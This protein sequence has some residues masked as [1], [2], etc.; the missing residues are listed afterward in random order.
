MKKLLFVILGG[1]ILFC[2][3]TNAQGKKLLVEINSLK[4]KEVIGFK[5]DNK[6]KLVYFDEKS[7][8]TYREFTL[9]YDKNSGKLSECVNN[10]DKGEFVY[11]S[12]F[13]YNHPD[14]IEEEMKSTGKK[15]NIKTTDNNKIFID[16]KNR[17]TKSMFDD[18]KLW[19]ELE[20]DANDNIVKYTLHSA[21]G[22]NDVITT[23]TYNN[24]KSIFSDIE[25]MPSWFWALHMN[26]MRWCTDFTGKNNP[27]ERTVIDPRFGTEVINITYDYDSDGYPVKQY[28]N[29]E[30]VKEFKYIPVK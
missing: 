23:N 15:I 22:D 29:N 10:N 17:L 21:L 4:T 6:N 25:N 3:K 20:Y 16:G 11:T 9:K 1:L 30:L 18:G 24:D 8:A 12:K 14:Y 5:Y 2:A 19:E 27:K 7:V 13:S 28:Y 26:N